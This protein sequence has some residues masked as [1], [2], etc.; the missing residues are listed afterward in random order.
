MLSWP[1][2]SG[3]YSVKE[4]D[5]M[6]EDER[7]KGQAPDL[8]ISV[9]L[10]EIQ[11]VIGEMGVAMARERTRASRAEQLAAGLLREREGLKELVKELESRKP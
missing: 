11:Q 2:S 10:V 6:N 7:S 3:T 9:D 5:G 4:D 1:G 8:A